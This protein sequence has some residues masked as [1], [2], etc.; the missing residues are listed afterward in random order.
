MTDLRLPRPLSTPLELLEGLRD[1]LR[2]A[3]ARR[4]V[5]ER[6]GRRAARRRAQWSGDGSRDFAVSTAGGLGGNGQLVANGPTGV[7]ARAWLTNSYDA[8]LET[9]AAVYLNATASAHL[10]ARGQNLATA[11]PSYYAVNVVRG[12]EVQL[13]RVNKGV[14]TVLGSAKTPDYLSN[15]WVTVTLRADGDNLR[16]FLHRGDTNQHLGHDGAYTRQRTA[17]IEVTDNAVRG[18]GQVG[19]ARGA[20]NAGEVTFDSLRVGPASATDAAPLAEERFSQP[21]KGLPAGWSSWAGPG[22]FT[23]ATVADETLR[24]D[25]ASATEGRAWLTRAVASDVQVSSSIYVDSLVPAGLIARGSNLA[26]ATETGYGLN[27]KRGLEVQLTRTVG[28]RE[29]TLADLTSKEWLSGQWVQASLVLNGDQLR[30]Q[31]YRSDTGQYL[32]DDGTWGLLPAWA[33]TATDDTIKSGS[34]VGLTRGHGYAGAVAFDN[35]IVTTAP[36]RVAPPTPI[37]SEVDKPTTP[38]NPGEDLP[39]PAPPRVPPPAVVTPQA[40]AASRPTP[41]PST[42]NAALPTVARNYDHIRLANL[43]YY[44]TPFGDFEQ[45]LLRNSVDLVIPNTAYLDTIDAINS[46]TPQFVYSNVSNI[47]LNLLTDWNEYADR[48]QL[49]REAAF[50]HAAKATEYRGASASSVPVNQ[51]W[52]VYRTAA[53]ATST[54]LTRDARKSGTK[55]ALPSNGGTLALGYLEKFRELNVDIATAP[56]GNWSGAW[57]YVSA[58]DAAGNPTRWTT[59]RTLSDGTAGLRRDGR[60]T[61]DPPRDWVAASV[62]GSARLFYVRLKASGIGTAPTVN[63]ILGRD[64]TANQTIPAFDAAADRDG[65]GYLSDTEYAR[66][67]SGFDARFAYESRVFYPNYGPHRLATNVSDPAFRGW[68]ADYHARTLA[69]QPHADGFFVDNSIG[70]LILDP[71]TI[72]ESLDTYSDDYG[73]LLGGIE[74]QLRRGGHWLIANTAGGNGTSDPV[75]K[76]GVSAL[77]EFALRPLSANHVQYDDLAATLKYRRELANGRAYEILDSLPGNGFDADDPRLQL[78]TLAMYYTVADPDLSFLMVNGG[79][80]PAS[81]WQRH[82]IEAAT[83]NVGKPKAT[84]SLVATGTDPANSSLVYKVYGR[85]YDNALVLYK[86]LSY[87][88]GTNG[89]TAANTATTHQLDS[90]YRPL[91]ADGSLGNPTRTVTLRNGEG[92]VLVRA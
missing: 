63:T 23:A 46:D 28:G 65:D 55:V 79:N 48:N 85:E 21:A 44:G 66:R 34:F 41:T 25:A 4:G 17:A 52:G 62:G 43:A 12:A 82:W 80:E 9:S 73:S 60:I 69:A 58:V 15:R 61:F 6:P 5:P 3:V 53:D 56:Q 13:V 32:N 27:V 78:A 89:T 16:V 11:T 88:R 35:F 20:Q 91:N 37:P 47:Y 29:V 81:A 40:P 7:P 75:F 50:Y 39:R 86:P 74:Q 30:A 33:L 71:S 83:Y 90:I 87:T 14:E 70:R 26:T 45:S 67:Q 57:E 92:A 64:Y 77:E 24:L 76:N 49:D 31:I 68:A 38:A 19:F 18:S 84:Q 42:G 1:A 36:D 72:R 59:L 10:F 54:D 51:F 2:R 8:N 22:R